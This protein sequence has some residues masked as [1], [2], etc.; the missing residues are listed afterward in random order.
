M[1]ASY[2]A[3]NTRSKRPHAQDQHH[4]D[5]AGNT[6]FATMSTAASGTA[7]K[8]APKTTS[9]TTSGAASTAVVATH[10]LQSKAAGHKS[11]F[12]AAPSAAADASALPVAA[13]TAQALNNSPLA[14]VEGHQGT[15]RSR[16]QALQQHSPLAGTRLP[17]TRNLSP[18][19]IVQY[20]RCVQQ[21][22]REYAGPLYP[23]N[24]APEEALTPQDMAHLETWF[25]GY[26]A[27]EE[28]SQSR[29]EL[30]RRAL[31]WFL[32]GL[33]LPQTQADTAGTRWPVCP[34]RLPVPGPVPDLTAAQADQPA[35]V[36]GEAGSAEGSAA[37]DDS[38]A[39]SDA[40]DD[41]EQATPRS[42]RLYDPTDRE[43]ATVFALLEAEGS[44]DAA[45]TTMWLQALLASGLRPGELCTAKLHKTPD[46]GILS[47]LNEKHATTT[48][49]GNGQVRHLCYSGPGCRK[50]LECIERLLQR[51]QEICG[52]EE[53]A[54]S[55]L[56]KRC[57]RLLHK[58]QGRGIRI[59]NGTGYYIHGYTMRHLFA[60]EA[61]RIIRALHLDTNLVSALMGHAA[62]NSAWSL[63]ADKALAVQSGLSLPLPISEDQ[64]R[65][66]L[67]KARPHAAPKTQQNI[68]NTLDSL[69][70]VH[71]LN[72]WK[73]P[74]RQHS[75]PA[76]GRTS[77]WQHRE[78]G[79]L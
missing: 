55:S 2:P 34:A 54:C 20:A 66:R 10:T 45:L 71:C 70:A 79:S 72:S 67:N 4:T 17:G 33:A 30:C 40:D 65:V 19:T 28:L 16:W 22:L 14:A 64:A 7:A 12:F 27:R 73:Q 78:L 68:R 1:P 37:E 48:M 24:P 53:E 58:V 23:G 31:H 44:A 74:G 9:K 63:Y 5:H 36:Q 51:L 26:C 59:V 29:R 52:N 46:G 35:V 76:A 47:V 77:T 8:E 43:L 6:M 21:L 62:P 18:D 61:K 42:R 69:D 49:A 38:V 50:R 39:D 75:R 57:A 56:Y 11:H 13:P 3:A 32:A 41:A 60:A 25:A 15:Q